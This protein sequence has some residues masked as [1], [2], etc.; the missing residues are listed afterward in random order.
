MVNGTARLRL[1]E[2]TEQRLISAFL[3]GDFPVGGSLPGERDLAVQLGVTR[4]TLRE[5]LQR[6]ARDGW[7]AIQHGKP[8]RVNDFW[9]EG[10][11]HVLS[12]MARHTEW[13]PEQLVADLL[14]VRLA[15]APAYTYSA[16][17]R[18][19][20]EL[21]LFL[22]PYPHLEDSSSVLAGADW[23]L[24]LVLIRAAGNPVFM[25][26][27]NSFGDLYREV[28][29]AYFDSPPARSASYRF[30]REL[31]AASENGDA[32]AARDVACR[33]MAQSVTLWEEMMT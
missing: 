15:L 6:L 14:A 5:A 26:I 4:P 2:L 23:E 12:A 21:A 18:K 10:N 32:A 8:T 24:H 16:I 28:A 1:A 7:I 11:L 27:Y 33:A 19:H 22:T 31:L 9:W 25:L 20:E 17:Q 30:Y 13:V 3:R 29:R